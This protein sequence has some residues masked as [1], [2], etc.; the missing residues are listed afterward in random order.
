MHLHI[1]YTLDTHRHAHIYKHFQIAYVKN[2]RF[3]PNSCFKETDRFQ[4]CRHRGHIASERNILVLAI[5][6]DTRRQKKLQWGCRGCPF[7]LW[8]GGSHLP[9]WCYQNA[10]PPPPPIENAPA[11]DPNILWTDFPQAS[12]KHSDLLVQFFQACVSKAWNAVH[13]KAKMRMIWKWA[14]SLD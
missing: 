13:P 1:Y 6:P 3:L 14:Y 4:W 12:R 8:P 2:W 10:P 7:L 5:A 11:R 9:S